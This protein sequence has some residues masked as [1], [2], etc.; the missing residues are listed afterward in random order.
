MSAALREELAI[1]VDRV[2]NFK[3]NGRYV[4]FTLL[5]A[6]GIKYSFRIRLYASNGKEPAPVL[7]VISTPEECKKDR[8]EDIPTV[9]LN[10]KALAISTTTSTVVGHFQPLFNLGPEN[11]NN[12]DDAEALAKNESG[13]AFQYIRNAIVEGMEKEKEKAVQAS[14]H[15]PP[16]SIKCPVQEVQ[17][18]RCNIA[19][20][21]AAALLKH[22]RVAHSKFMQKAPAHR[23]RAIVEAVERAAK[24]KVYFCNHCKL[25][26]ASNGHENKCKGM[27]SS[28][29]P[30]SSSST[31]SASKVAPK[32]SNS[33]TSSSSSTSSKSDSV[34]KGM[35]E[36]ES[37]KFFHDLDP[38]AVIFNIEAGSRPSKDQAKRIAQIC[39]S[40]IASLAVSIEAKRGEAPASSQGNSPDASSTSAISFQYEA[41]FKKFFIFQSLLTSK[42]PKG[43]KKVCKW[44]N[45]NISLWNQNRFKELLDRVSYRREI[46]NAGEEEEEEEKS[47]PK[48]SMP[49]DQEMAAK[50]KYAKRQIM[51]GNLQKAYTRLAGKSKFTTLEE[52][53]LDEFEKSIATTPINPE[54]E[55]WDFFQDLNPDEF[56]TMDEV[57]ENTESFLEEKV[58]D[59][60]VAEALG[61]ANKDSGAGASNW[62]LRVLATAL[63]ENPQNLPNVTTIVKSFLRGLVPSSL[64]PFLVGHMCSPLLKSSGKIRPITPSE[65]FLRLVGKIV[66]AAVPS[67]IRQAV[68]STQR[69]I[70][71]RSGVEV[72]GQEINVAQII[73]PDQVIIKLDLENAFNNTSRLAL[74]RQVRRKDVGMSFLLNFC[75]LCYGGDNIVIAPKADGGYLRL[76]SQEGLNQGDSMSPLYHCIVT[77]PLIEKIKELSTAVTSIMDDT[78]VCCSVD[79]VRSIFDLVLEE[80]EKVGAILSADKAAVYTAN[81]ET[82]KQLEE[83]LQQPINGTLQVKVIQEDHGLEYLSTPIGSEEFKTQYVEEEKI[84]ELVEC[85]KNIRLLED[86]QMESL[87]FK[88]IFSPKINYSLRT[89]HPK[90]TMKL[91]QKHNELILDWCAHVLN[92][93]ELGDIPE[94]TVAKIFRSHSLGGFGFMDANITRFTAFT[95][96]TAQTLHLNQYHQDVDGFLR[97]KDADQDQATLWE[98]SITDVMHE[99]RN[100]ISKAVDNGE[101][102]TAMEWLQD[103]KHLQEAAKV[104]SL[105]HILTT[106][107][108]EGIRDQ[109]HADL[110]EE[111]KAHEL[112]TRG[113]GA[114][115]F[116]STFP[117]NPH[118][119]ISPEEFSEAMAVFLW[120]DKHPQLTAAQHQHRNGES[121]SLTPIHRLAC[122]DSGGPITRHDNVKY[123]HAHVLRQLGH[124]SVKIEP[125]GELDTDNKTGADISF[126]M[127]NSS[128]R[129]QVDITC[130]LVTSSAH[131]KK[132]S[133]TPLASAD[134]AETL[135]KKK[136]S[137]SN[138]SSNNNMVV[139]AIE[140]GGAFGKPFLK[141]IASITR[142]NSMPGS[143]FNKKLRHLS[144][145]KRVIK[146]LSTAYWKGT[147]KMVLDLVESSSAKKALAN[148]NNNTNNNNKNNNNKNNKKSK[149]NNNG[150]GDKDGSSG[151]GSSG[152][153]SGSSG[154]SSSSSRDSSSSSSSS[155]DSSRDSGK[156]GRGTGGSA[157]GKGKGGGASGKGRSHAPESS[158]S[159]STS[160]GGRSSGGDSSSSDVHDRISFDPPPLTMVNLGYNCNSNPVFLHDPHVMPSFNYGYNHGPFLGTYS[161]PGFLRAFC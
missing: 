65:T 69:G 44:I 94:A 139:A 68:G 42:P 157:G 23:S 122:K 5:A 108:Q 38:E 145:R 85:Y 119:Q 149:K 43:N 79:Q 111:Q 55:E 135:K 62:S 150:K 48:I 32:A 133:T 129:T 110:S 12:E 75:H 8:D 11:N 92:V 125:R 57:K 82:A 21:D 41:E 45:E 20:A 66:Y 9:N 100:G 7:A 101:R 70:C 22:F 112:S 52:E 136:Y 47:Q 63:E 84:E 4:P 49:P 120:Y 77:A 134:S 40:V 109:F 73:Y 31:S 90:Y 146:I 1:D 88:Y 36:E 137:N 152:S 67:D 91:A 80:G 143:S 71:T 58:T 25:P 118:L 105:Q 117:S 14:F 53:Q 87:M 98:K 64:S 156:G 153:S 33:S 115:A 97:S 2:E 28:S 74:A 37:A 83:E 102:G 13:P 103:L 160:G 17:G 39:N 29:T 104:F 27:P 147:G 121:H 106:L 61:K 60:A 148:N 72:S 127:S 95:A 46:S 54:E 93:E 126:T 19:C 130:V 155:G 124:A 78:I 99:V 6:L 140:S 24:R 151:G 59:T 159:G 34:D 114:T 76:L 123:A 138:Q 15:S 154:S 131:V 107:W 18:K 81:A 132:A 161:P 3:Q 128:K 10:F 51:A 116:L 142:G 50:I 86:P 35:S 144:S 158:S 56:F 141:H 26:F 89:I 113:E 16:G 96:A 30:S